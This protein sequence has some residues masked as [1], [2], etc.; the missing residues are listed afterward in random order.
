MPSLFHFTVLPFVE[1]SHKRHFSFLWTGLSSVWMAGG[2]SSNRGY[3]KD[4]YPHPANPSGKHSHGHA[5]PTGTVFS[6][7]VIFPIFLEKP[8]GFHF[9][10]S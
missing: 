1:K 8:G 4:C 6:M 7:A 9:I 3:G 5:P 10:L 2:F